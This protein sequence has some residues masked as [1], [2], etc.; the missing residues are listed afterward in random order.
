MTERPVLYLIDGSA[1]LY[2]A[3]FALPDLST[4]T[5]LPTNAVYGFTTMLQ[6]VIRERHPEYLAVAFDEKGPTLRHEEFKEYKAHRPP[7]PDALSRQIPYIHRVVEAFA[8][9]VV[10]LA[11]YEADDLIGTLAAQAASQGLEVVI[12]TGDKDMYQL[13]SPA[14]RIYDPVKDKFLTEEDC[15]VRFG[16]EPALVVEVMGLMGDATDNIPGVKGIGEKTAKK[17]IAEFGTIENLL[18]HLS[19]VK[20]DK[21]R[22]LLEAHVDEARQSR[23]LATIVTDC[24][25]TFDRERFRLG[26][27]RTDELSAL[28]RE[29][30]FW[31]LLN[32]LHKQTGGETRREERVAVL[33]DPADRSRTVQAIR[34]E[35]AV[36]IH[37]DLAGA[38]PFGATVRG[39]GV[40][41]GTGQAS[42]FPGEDGLADLRPVLEDPAVHVYVHDAK[43]AWLALRRTG[44]RLT[45]RFD[46]MV[47]GYLLNPNRRS[48]AL[49]TLAQEYLAES[50]GH[51]PSGKKP[52]KEDLFEQ[53]DP[54][55]TAPRA[56]GAASAIAR[57]QPI[58]AEKLAAAGMRDLF[59]RVEIPL[60]VVLGEM[61]A[62]GFRVD[63]GVLARLSKELESQ[64]DRILDEIY[65]KAGT[66]FNVN[67]PKQLSEVLFEKLKLPPVKKTKTGYSTD[68]EVL[69]QLAL[70]HDLP[71]DIL[72]YRSLSKLK[73][74]YVDA[75]PLLVRPETG[76]L[77]T[78]MNQTITATGRLSSSEPNLQNIPVKGEWGMRIREA[79]VA[80]PGGLLLSADYNQIEP[81]I[82]AH[83]S[84]DPVL[85][86][87][88]AR[89]DDIHTATAVEIFNLPAAQIT[90]DMRRVAKTVN[91][92]IIYGIS[93]YGLSAQLGISQQEAKKYIEAYFTRFQG[94][95]AFLDGT[96]A[97]AKE[98]GYVTTL[99]G[100]RRPIMELRSGDPTQR[101]MGERMAMNTPIQGTAADVIKLAMLA[102][103]GRL[104][105]EGASAKMILQVHDELIFEVAEGAIETVRKIVVEEMERVVTLAVPLKVDVGV[106]RNWREAHP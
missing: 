82:L 95:K 58:L 78:S 40:C 54:E 104:Q 46:T 14:V 86:G 85:I 49:E 87:A 100:R 13:L 56:A 80:E 34:E 3:F 8:I 15:L 72:N 19:E 93:P 43:A 51:A 91:F 9:P 74:T 24:P 11:G 71:A 62:T 77:H 83:L 48:P 92:G 41:A 10:K 60:T 55:E 68:E 20:G 52:K 94:V 90:K 67:S 57:L 53:R 2:R 12:V 102:V 35:E 50:L 66:E 38:D 6:K 98:K 75:L 5:G 64:L 22:G 26:E 88:F 96:I 29:L 65:R 45:P 33:D 101:S 37:C 4:S 84:Q 76:R 106:G 17:L 59:E 21:L 25:V 70:Q 1:Y 103:R 89:G 69:T 23:K 44:I 36:A 18:T 99:L 27:S 61:E 79:F 105:E 16:V 63:T 30:E 28:Y 42:Y 39:I 32:T 31:G 7:M 97:E 81:R 73:S 47:A